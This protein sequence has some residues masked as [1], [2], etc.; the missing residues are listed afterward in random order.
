[1]TNSPVSERNAL[2]SVLRSL[3]F[4]NGSRTALRKGSYARLPPRFAAPAPLACW[5]NHPGAR[6]HSPPHIYRSLN[7]TSSP[8]MQRSRGGLGFSGRAAYREAIGETFPVSPAPGHFPERVQFFS[9]SLEKGVPFRGVASQGTVRRGSFPLADF[10]G[11]PPPV[12]IF[13]KPPPH[14]PHGSV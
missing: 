12:V 14:P 4:H 3:S 10:L 9:L 2:K 5:I 11:D 8:P 6:C 7:I 1:M 13:M